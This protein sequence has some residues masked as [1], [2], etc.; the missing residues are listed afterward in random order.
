MAAD[1]VLAVPTVVA[2]Y[3]SRSFHRIG[4]VGG[5]ESANRS[6]ERWLSRE[7]PRAGVGRKVVLCYPVGEFGYSV[8]EFE[9]LQCLPPGAKPLVHG[10]GQFR[11]PVVESPDGRRHLGDGLVSPER[12]V[13]EQ[14]D[15]AAVIEFHE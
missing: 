5:A 9:R 7:A 15:K 8:G 14:V 11:L 4:N 6:A 1:T 2:Q 3:F 13:V 10:R 12:R